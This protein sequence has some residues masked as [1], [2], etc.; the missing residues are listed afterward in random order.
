MEYFSEA[1]SNKLNYGETRFLVSVAALLLISHNFTC[2]WWIMTKF[3][4]N[5]EDW[6]F[7]H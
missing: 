2:Y 3:Q 1:F 5:P 6:A 4:A 7:T